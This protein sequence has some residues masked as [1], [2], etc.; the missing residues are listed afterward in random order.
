MY[1]GTRLRCGQRVLATGRVECARVKRNAKNEWKS[2][3]EYAST[4]VREKRGGGGRE[5]LAEMRSRARLSRRVR[6][7]VRAPCDWRQRW[8]PQP[9][10]SPPTT[11][12]NSQ[13]PP[14][15]A[16]A[17]FPAHPRSVSDVHQSAAAVARDC[18]HWQPPKPP[19]DEVAADQWR[20]SAASIRPTAGDARRAAPQIR[21]TFRRVEQITCAVRRIAPH[22]TSLPPR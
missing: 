7:R 9:Q 11:T 10:L 3:R 17:Y 19:K 22:R 13:L 5:R 1:I 21:P 4:R 2:V 18:N 20:P 15:C 14:L 16:V 6:Q 12:N 8:P